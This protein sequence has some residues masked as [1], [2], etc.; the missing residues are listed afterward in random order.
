MV[1]TE[2]SPQQG[3][4]DRD[5]I[6][7]CQTGLEMLS[8]LP[9]VT[10][11]VTQPV[12]VLCVCTAAAVSTTHVESQRGQFGAADPSPSPHRFSALLPAIE[13]MKKAYQEELSRELNKTRS[14]QQGPDGL[15]KQ[16]Q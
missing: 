12:P 8:N 15:R 10:Q 16:H 14:L 9:K 7:S 2:M 5:V 4:A 11:L 1:S 3:P 6:P 13:A